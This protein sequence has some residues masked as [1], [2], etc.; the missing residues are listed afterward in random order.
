MEEELAEAIDIEERNA[1]V[2][3]SIQ[4]LARD[5]R[6]IAFCVTINHARNLARSL[7]ALGVPAGLVHGALSS[8]A[9]ARP[10]TISGAA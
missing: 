1:L 8:E 3:R 4:E 2:A 6:T 9:R 10:W 5:R 7:N